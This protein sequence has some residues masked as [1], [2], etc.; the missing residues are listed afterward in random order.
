MLQKNKIY[1]VIRLK[2][3]P[4]K[5]Y[6]KEVLQLLITVI[7]TMYLNKEKELSLSELRKQ[8]EQANQ[9]K[10]LF[11]A[12]MSHEL[13]TPLNAIIGFSQLLML[14][15]NIS[16]KHYGYVDNIS[17]SGENLLNLVNTILDFA[18]LEAGNLNFSPTLTPIQTIIDESVNMIKAMSQK[19]SIEFIYPKNNSLELYIDKKL[20]KQVLLNLLTNAIKFTENHGRIELKIHLDKYKQAYIFSIFDTGIGIEQEGIND[21]FEPFSQVENSFQ[22]SHK[23]TGLGLPIVKKI[24]ENIHGGEIWVESQIGEGSQFYFTIPINQEFNIIKENN[25]DI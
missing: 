7:Q 14:D 20:I 5:L 24:I 15:K 22:K 6:I 17:V 12:N 4:N 8:A 19:K 9:A 1:L 23:G 13:R 2:E 3:I 21:L 16:E 10:D 25:H 11:L 18:K